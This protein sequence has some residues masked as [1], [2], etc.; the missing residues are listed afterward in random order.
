M[1]RIIESLYWT[2]ETKITLYVNYTVIKTK[3]GK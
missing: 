1:N 3:N 2:P